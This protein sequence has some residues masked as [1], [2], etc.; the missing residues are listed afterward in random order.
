MVDDE[1]RE[2]PDVATSLTG[3]KPWQSIR[4]GDHC[5]IV[6]FGREE[7][8]LYVGTVGHRSSVSD[9]FP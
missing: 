3:L 2:P 7:L 4:V 1:F 9:D 8:I 5:I 6:R